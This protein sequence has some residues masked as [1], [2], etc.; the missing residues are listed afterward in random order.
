VART[1]ISTKRSFFILMFLGVKRWINF[2]SRG[3]L[4]SEKGGSKL[5]FRVIGPVIVVSATAAIDSRYNWRII[6][7]LKEERSIFAVFAKEKG[8]MNK[9]HP[10]IGAKA[11]D[12]S[13]CEPP[14]KGGGYNVFAIASR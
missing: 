9:S 10:L 2:D 13:T 4:A 3:K 1:G 5:N 12:Q 8:I 7:N 14:P 11:L 6:P